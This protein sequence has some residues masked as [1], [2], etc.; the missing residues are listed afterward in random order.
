[1]SL[2]K[3]AASNRGILGAVKSF[4]GNKNK[5]TDADYLI[6]ETI[7]DNGS[8]ETIRHHIMI[9]E[10]KNNKQKIKTIRLIDESIKK[11]K[12]HPLENKKMIF[13]G[14][15]PH[16]DSI[17]GKYIRNAAK[18]NGIDVHFNGDL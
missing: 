13:E 14:D 4:F 9:T 17:V 7:H 11:L 10:P 1:M 3:I 8:G 18:N 15:I 16:P 2:Y 5:E 12:K 6:G